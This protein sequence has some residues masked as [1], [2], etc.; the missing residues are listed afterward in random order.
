MAKCLKEVS[1]TAGLPEGK[2]TPRSLRKLYQN[3]MEELEAEGTAPAEQALDRRMEQ[4]D[5]VYGWGV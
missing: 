5:A 1:Q 3:T 2:G 4:E